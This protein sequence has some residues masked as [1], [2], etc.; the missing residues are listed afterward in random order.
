METLEK[1]ETLI[2]SMSYS[3]IRKFKMAFKDASEAGFT[4]E[5][6]EAL[7]IHY[8]AC[9]VL[10]VLGGNMSA[11]D[12]QKLKTTRL[13]PEGGE[14][15]KLRQALLEAAGGKPQKLHALFAWYNQTAA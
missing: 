5:M 7:I 4:E 1:H 15:H 13:R 6:K 10:E 9:C 2:A 3:D 14:E 12:K 8:A 11:R